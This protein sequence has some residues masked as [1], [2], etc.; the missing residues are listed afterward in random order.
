MYIHVCIK[1]HV[2]DNV[3]L[4]YVSWFY[5]WRYEVFSFYTVEIAL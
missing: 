4:W 1:R 3:S 5:D 2:H